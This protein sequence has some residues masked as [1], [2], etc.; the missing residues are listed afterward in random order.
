M[1]ENHMRR[2][3]ALGYEKGFY[4]KIGNPNDREITN[5]DSK[6]IKSDEDDIS[7]TDT[8]APTTTAKTTSLL[9]PLS[10]NLSYSQYE[11]D[12]IRGQDV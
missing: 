9:T 6:N 1:E 2:F 3:T 7:Q 10:K 5:L 11:L 12:S 4:K 8:N